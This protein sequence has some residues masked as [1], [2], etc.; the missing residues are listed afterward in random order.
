VLPGRP[1]IE[2]VIGH[3]NVDAPSGACAQLGELAALRAVEAWAAL[4]EAS[5]ARV[6][7]LKLGV[8]RRFSALALRLLRI[9][10]WNSSY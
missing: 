9:G 1:K 8:Q 10:G 6:L 2:E 5:S 7:R 4:P 3:A